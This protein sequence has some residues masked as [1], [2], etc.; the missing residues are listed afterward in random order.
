MRTYLIRRLLLFV[1]VL[2]GVTLLVFVVMRVMPGDVAMSILNPDGNSD[3]DP[4]RY[5]KLREELGLNR[6]LYQQYGS[7]IVGIARGDWG[8]SLRTQA[9][10]LAEIK[11]RLPLTMEIT[12]LTV[13]AAISIGIPL[14][15]LM[16]IRQDGW[17]DYVLR[18]LSIGGVAIPNFWIG[19]LMLLGMVVWFHWR[20]PAGYAAVWDSPWTNLK[21]VIWPCLAL[22]YLQSAIISR[23]TRSAMLEVLRQ[24]Y[25][26]TAWAKGLRER[27]VVLRHALRNALLP[28]VT[29]VGLQFTALM[30][31]TVIMENLWNLPGVGRSLLDAIGFR[32]YPMIQALVLL[33]AFFALVG[34]LV[35]DFLYA[36]LDP[37]VRYSEGP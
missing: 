17:A 28:V 34:N 27:T 4:A 13:L 21:Q 35:V 16:A 5:E 32:D 19:T 2:L 12:L 10:V 33:F 15:V 36:W 1:P 6:P 22:G 31:G 11:A 18:I 24:D 14:G 25:V 8:H 20:P 9:P 37:R 30:G 26:R 23:M 3:V 29:L 7:W